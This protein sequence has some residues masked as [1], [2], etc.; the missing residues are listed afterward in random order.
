MNRTVVVNNWQRIVIVLIGMLASVFWIMAMSRDQSYFFVAAGVSILLFGLLPILAIKEFDWFC[1]WSALILAILYGCTL[2]SICMTYNLPNEEFVSENILLH[3][4]VDHFV[5]PTL[6]LMGAIF[7]IGVGY[8]GYPARERVIN[9]G[10]VVNPARLL[11]ICAVCGGIAFL[12][13]AAYF[14]LNGG[15]SG[16]LS[17]KRGTITTI[18]VGADTGFSQHGYLRQ[19]AKL[20]NIALLLLAAYW[21]K[22]HVRAGSG[23]GFVRFMILGA[24]LL[25][26]VAFPFYS[27]SRAGVVWVVIGFIGVLYYMQQKIVSIKS[28]AI[29]SVILIMVMFSTVVRNDGG[30]THSAADRIGRLLLNRHGPDIAVTSHI[31]QN[32]PHKLEYK[33]GET[34]AV[35]LLAPVPRELYPAKPLIHSGPVIGQT[36][37]GLNVSGV[38]PGMVAE[39]YW[40]FHILGVI[41]GCVIFGVYMKITYQTCKNLV[42]DPVLVIPI[43]IYAV[44]PIAFKAVTHSIGPAVIMPCVELVT[45]CFIVYVVSVT[46]QFA[47]A[48]SQPVSNPAFGDSQVSVT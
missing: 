38:P 46:A 17:S 20:G 8:F 25:L 28:I 19:F 26:S 43:Y 4:P 31:V 30:E 13:F 7:C 14:V 23:T 1:P 35:W 27:S 36:L 5:K 44:F 11:P 40:N 32:I 47:P 2:P 37:Y 24:L 29:V 3:Q 18:D 33:H 12:A 42:A 45:V 21:S 39:L 16:G 41:F 48:Q 34:I 6:M 9:I 10:R 22:F 15:L